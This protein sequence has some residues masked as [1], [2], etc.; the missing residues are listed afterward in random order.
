MLSLGNYYFLQLHP[1]LS[2][3]STVLFL[4]HAE[5]KS[6]LEMTNRLIRLVETAAVPTSRYSLMAPRLLFGAENCKKYV[7]TLKFFS[8]KYVLLKQF[9]L[10]YISKQNAF[11]KI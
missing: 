1:K 7:Y 9:F 11:L 10:N 4:S 3:G 5:V 2:E 8:Q 6:P